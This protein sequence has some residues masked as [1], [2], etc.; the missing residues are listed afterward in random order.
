MAFVG[1]DKDNNPKYCA[2]R[3]IGG[4]KFTQ[5]V[6]NSEKKHGFCMKG[7]SNRVFICES[8]VDVI[9]HATLTKMNGRDYTEDSRLSLGGVTEDAL[10][11]FLA[12]NP[13][14]NEIVFALD[15]DFEKLN[16]KGEPFNVGQIKAES[17]S[18]KYTKKGFKTL[19]QTPKSKDFNEQLQKLVKPSAV[20]Q[21]NDLKKVSQQKESPV[22]PLKRECQR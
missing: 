1:T 18:K 21:L 13:Q 17:L 10:I 2:L 19:I 20:K 16:S 12:D 7:R 6:K 15:N 11:Q 9:S 4:K 14:I 5:D 22:K 8:P 3:S